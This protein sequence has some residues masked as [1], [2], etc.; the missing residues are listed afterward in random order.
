[1]VF[2]EAFM[3]HIFGR[4]EMF[5]SCLFQGDG[6]GILQALVH[7]EAAFEQSFEKILSSGVTFNG[8]MQKFKETDVAFITAYLTGEDPKLG[9]FGGYGEGEVDEAGDVRRSG[10]VR[11]KRLNNIRNKGLGQVLRDMGYGWV[12][13]KG[14]YGKP[15][16]TFI[17]FNVVERQDRF[18]D[19]MKGLADI[20]SQDSVLLCPKGGQWCLYYPRKRKSKP[21]MEN[22]VHE[23]LDEVAPAFYT[24][25][26]SHKF[27]VPFDFSSD[28]DL[29]DSSAV[30]LQWAERPWPAP[31]QVPLARRYVRGVYSSLT[32]DDIERLWR[33]VANVEHLTNLMRRV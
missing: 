7:R 29:I 18:L 27:E 8:L 26:A 11:T 32:L 12:T 13:G 17:V 4:Y 21:A 19:D 16:K 6:Q 31:V 20:F 5:E 25:Y 33:G 28:S 3:A 2:A 1:M 14:H 10:E 24:Q 15:E 22:E 30:D 23:F 9:G